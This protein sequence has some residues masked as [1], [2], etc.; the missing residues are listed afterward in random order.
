MHILQQLNIL[1]YGSVVDMEAIQK[2]TAI[3]PWYLS[4]DAKK[5]LIYHPNDFNP[6]TYLGL[7]ESSES[8]DSDDEF[9]KE[10]V[11]I[12]TADS[13]S[14]ATTQLFNSPKVFI[15]FDIYIKQMIKCGFPKCKNPQGQTG[16]SNGV[17][18][19]EELL[20]TPITLNPGFDFEEEI[21]KRKIH[22]ARSE[23]RNVWKKTV[24]GLKSIKS[25][26]SEYT[27]NI[28]LSNIGVQDALDTFYAAAGDIYPLLNELPVECLLNAMNDGKSVICSVSRE[29]QKTSSIDDFKSA[30][31]HK[32]EMTKI[33]TSKATETAKA[34]ISKPLADLKSIGKQSL[35]ALGD[36]YANSNVYSLCQRRFKDHV[37]DTVGGKL[38]S[39][40]EGLKSFY[41]EN[42]LG[43]INK[44]LDNC[45]M[46][47]QANLVINNLNG[48][49]EAEKQNFNDIVQ[50][51]NLTSLNN[52][53]QNNDNLAKKFGNGDLGFN[54][55]E[56]QRAAQLNP[57]SL[58]A[59][60]V[61]LV[62]KLNPLNIVEGFKSKLTDPQFLIDSAMSAAK[63]TNIFQQ[64]SNMFQ[65]GENIISQFGTGAGG[66]LDAIKGEIPA[67]SKAIGG[68]ESKQEI[69]ANTIQEMQ[70]YIA[71]KDKLYAKLNDGKGLLN[72]DK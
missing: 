25:S 38:G 64:D 6:L 67:L 18:G 10:Y 3:S 60:K 71:E 12:P 72:K 46:K 1:S 63:T 50:T 5:F 42:L 68:K 17:C 22:T 14:Q 20:K 29:A 70:A 8:K 31:M 28:K 30:A 23:V 54:F 39:I 36:I 26:V 9:E 58:I 24:D 7:A 34:Q 62:K 15:D 41:Q 19:L 16:T 11:Y 32:W 69:S 66:V 43:T 47:G 55:S 4:E 51:G 52:F 49:T 65:M 33:L 44:V 53:I 61:E 40:S 57:N 37:Q 21:K 59:T 2:I 45:F 35:D 27:S 48:L 56:F 13:I